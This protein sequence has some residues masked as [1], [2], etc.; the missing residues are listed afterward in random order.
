VIDAVVFD[1]DG[2]LWDTCATCAVAWNDVLRR[3]RIAFREITEADI[4]SIMGKPHDE[5]IR[6]I[7]VG[8][9]EDQLALL[10]AETASQDVRAVA[11]IGGTLYPGVGD[12]VARLSHRLPLFIVSNCQAGYIEA[13]LG[14]N[15]MGKHFRDFECWGN[16]GLS[17]AANLEK[18][19]E[20]NA[21]SS[22]IFVGDAPGDQ[23]A[24]RVCG[25]PFVYVDWGFGECHG[26]DRRFSSFAAL[27]DW[28]LLEGP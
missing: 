27:A 28:L 24:A 5:C 22:P 4:R 26:A 17:K 13:F 2:T 6:T 1:L 11:E 21:L 10:T 18:I 9:P 20:R 19:I 16:T 14:D 8:L 12:G 23:S 3:N 25:V 7:F 15:G